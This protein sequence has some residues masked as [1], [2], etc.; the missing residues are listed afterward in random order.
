MSGGDSTVGT[1]SGAGGASGAGGS[2]GTA[3]DC[4]N[5]FER[6][7]LASPVPAVLALLRSS[8]VLTLQ[9]Q[10]PQGPLLATIADGR[11]AGSI[12]SASLVRLL[13]CIAEGYGFVAIVLTV[14]G[15]K[16]DVEIRPAGV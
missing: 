4:T 10:S 16:C 9:A 1:G 12:T 13:R 7:T 3:Q 14:S 5:I 8:S 15:G 6:T 2:G 11:V